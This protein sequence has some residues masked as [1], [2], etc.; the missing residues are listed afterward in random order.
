MDGVEESE[1]VVVIGATNRPTRVDSA[2][3]RPGRFDELLYVPVPDGEARLHILEVLTRHVPL[4]DDV[5]L[6]ALTERTEGFTGADLADLVRRAGVGALRAASEAERISTRDFEKAFEETRASVTPE[7]A[8][9]YEE[10]AK[11]LRERSV[12]ARDRIG[13]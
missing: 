6:A 5:D 10:L 4:A 2:L 9:E 8:L 3:L 12:R 11:T 1:G 7:V 13:F